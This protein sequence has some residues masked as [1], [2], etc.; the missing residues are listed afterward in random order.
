LEDIEMDVKE[1]DGDDVA[2]DMVAGSCEHGNRILGS[3]K[4]SEFYF[5]LMLL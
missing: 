5:I 4:V 3:I 2:L 1:M